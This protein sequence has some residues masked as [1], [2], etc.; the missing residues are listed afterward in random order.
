MKKK[1]YIAPLTEIS[2][3]AIESQFMA[4]ISNEEWTDPGN[5]DAK[6]QGNF[7]DFDDDFGDTWDNQKDTKDLWGD[8]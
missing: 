3:M 7:F 6:E 1:V 8:N 4:A 5:S 2:L